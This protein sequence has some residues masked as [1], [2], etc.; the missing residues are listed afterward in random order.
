M[1]GLGYNPWWSEGSVKPPLYLTSTFMFR[2]AEE[3]EEFFSVA[4][5]KKRARGSQGLIY[6][7]LN[8]PELEILETRLAV[9]EEAEDAAVF[10]SG[11]AAI[12][13][14]VLALCK[15]GDTIA[16]T[17]PIYGGTSHFFTGIIN[18]FG[19]R[20]VAIDASDPV[21]ELL[22]LNDKRLKMVFVETP[23]NPTLLMTDLA[24][25]AE[26]RD[27]LSKRFGHEIV[28]CVDNTMLGPVFQKPLQF[29]CDLSLYSATKFIGGHSDLIAGAILGKHDLIQSIKGYRSFLGTMSSPFCSWLMM[30]SIETLKIRMETQAANASRVAQF[31]AAHLDVKQVYYPG[32]LASGSAQDNIRKKQ[33]TGDGSLI[34]FEVKGGKMRAFAVL[35]AMRLCRLAV[36]LG[37]TESLIEHPKTMTHSEMDAASQKRSG[38]TD[39]LIRLSVGLEDPADIIADLQQ[40]LRRK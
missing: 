13:S 22:A 29:G 17:I 31:L 26:A 8:N 20:A 39:G 10:A 1:M 23:S 33:C 30:R 15:P 4:L 21:R 27:R 14:T 35:N 9:W 36:S 25:I 2:T 16:Y 28:L 37:G 38:I 19:I 7:R 40:A 18:E 32:L 34:S 12:A 3:G 5:G 6:S 24:A 11:M